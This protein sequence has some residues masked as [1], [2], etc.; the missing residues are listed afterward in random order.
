MSATSSA[1]PQ[2]VGEGI[3]ALRVPLPIAS[4][5]YTLCYLIEDEAGAVHVVDPGWDL[6]ANRELLTGA[7]STLGLAL[8]RVSTVTVTH[9]HADHLGLAGWLR[10][11]S[12]ARV[13]LHPLEQQA[14]DELAERGDRMPD[15]DSWGVPADRRAELV[16]AVAGHVY[17]RFTADAFVEHGDLLAVEGR[18]LRVIHTP[19]HTSGSV[20]IHDEEQG[21]LFTGDTLLPSIF[22]GLG[23]G[24]DQGDPLRDY[25][26]SLDRL[27]ALGEP[28]VLPGHG[29]PFDGLAERIAEARS[30]QLVRTA[31]V[32]TIVAAD[33]QATVWQVASR[34][35]WTDGW[36]ALSGIR[37]ASALSQTAMRMR[38]GLTD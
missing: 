30:H 8:G 6:S 2:R 16:A 33:Q 14:L 22:A 25:L 36:Q 23:L 11:Q 17:P 21:L 18:T 34:V 28:R 24:G 37:L 20:S 38:F 32:E 31:E 35:T 5:P 4:P 7:L 1:A 26:D 9:L 12:G 13:L 3:W 10:E 15:L 27:E 29:A 19:G